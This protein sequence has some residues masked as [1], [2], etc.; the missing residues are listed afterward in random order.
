MKTVMTTKLVS[1]GVM[2]IE[3][4]HIVVSKV[5]K[6]SCMYGIVT[7]SNNSLKPGSDVLLSKWSEHLS[8][9]CNFFHYVD[10]K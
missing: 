5:V 4:L 10:R 3:R 1:I 2:C 6:S 8:D 7:F 9:I